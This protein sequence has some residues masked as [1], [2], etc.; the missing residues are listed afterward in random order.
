MSLRTRTVEKNVLELPAKNRKVWTVSFTLVDQWGFSNH[1][2]FSA[3]RKYC[4]LA[5]VH[6]LL[7]ILALFE[8]NFAGR[9]T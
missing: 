8:T 6:C 1:Y 3:L 7:E 5:F 9:K 4:N 2:K